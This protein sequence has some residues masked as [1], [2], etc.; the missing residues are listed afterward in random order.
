MSQT[1]TQ[2]HQ[3]NHNV[4]DQ[5]LQRTQSTLPTYTVN[6]YYSNISHYPYPPQSNQYTFAG[7]SPVPTFSYTYSGSPH[8]YPNALKPTPYS[9]A[10]Q[11][12]PVPTFP[13]AYSGS[14]HA[15]PNTNYVNANYCNN[16][17]M[18]FIYLFI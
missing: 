3:W 18:L 16:N 11:P 12:L 14:P 5:R 15:Y 7:P 6:N 17:S 2:Q 4:T 9:A 8:A 13:F 10:R 1:P